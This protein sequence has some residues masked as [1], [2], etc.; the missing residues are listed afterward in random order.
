MKIFSSTRMWSFET[1][2]TGGSGGFHCVTAPSAMHEIPYRHWRAKGPLIHSLLRAATSVE[3]SLVR[4]SRLT[5]T[6]WKKVDYF[7]LTAQELFLLIYTTPIG[8]PKSTALLRN[9]AVTS[10]RDVFLLSDLSR[11]RSFPAQRGSEATPQ[12]VPGPLFRR[13]FQANKQHD[14]RQPR[15]KEWS[16]GL[17]SSRC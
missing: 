17:A 12:W 10:L 2:E 3:P 16:P 4:W 6:T 9:V 8:K 13:L 11:R 15:G 14:R 1:K 5:A 7:P